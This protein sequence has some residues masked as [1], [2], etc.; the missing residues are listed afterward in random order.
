MERVPYVI[1][2]ERVLE[3]S[4]TLRRSKEG[5]LRGTEGRY[6]QMWTQVHKY[7]FLL[8]AFVCA[9]LFRHPDIFS[10]E[11]YIGCRTHNW[12]IN[13]AWVMGLHAWLMEAHLCWTTMS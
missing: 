5:G 8:V 4:G 6:L 10:L 11:P 13:T 3:P 2:F 12:I 9:G 1:C 7:G